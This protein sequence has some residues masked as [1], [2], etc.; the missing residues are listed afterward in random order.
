VSIPEIDFTKTDK[1]L[2]NLHIC[3]YLFIDPIFLIRSP[4]QMLYELLPL[5][6]VRRRPSVLIVFP[7]IEFSHSMFASASRKLFRI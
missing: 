3:I 4:V 2:P 7:E 1:K 6:G 5:L